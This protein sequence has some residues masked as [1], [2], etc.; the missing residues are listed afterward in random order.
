VSREELDRPAARKKDWV[1]TQDAFDTLLARL[2]PDP[3]RAGYEYENIRRRLITFFECR[4]SAIPEELADETI[5]RVARRIIEGTDI[6][7]S[8][9][10]G[11][12]Y[13]VARN[14]LSEFW[15][16][17]DACSSPLDHLPPAGLADPAQIPGANAAA[18]QKEQGLECLDHCLNALG[19][20]DRDLITSYYQGET[21]VKIR[22][23]KQLAAGRGIG[24]NA[25]RI[26]ALRIR[27]KLEQCVG[28]CLESRPS[29]RSSPA[30]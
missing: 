25:L 10:A 19:S 17:A 4:G 9:P 23:R 29:G 22:N 15:E 5:N 30:G 20:E 26:R 12:F 6:R 16:S 7:A 2:D 21:A 3:Q 14:V 13:G 18:E 27:E 28:R 1:L 24:A 8:N 11:Y